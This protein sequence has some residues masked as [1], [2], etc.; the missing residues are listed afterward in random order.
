MRHFRV[1]KICL[2]FCTN[3]QILRG[4]IVYNIRVILNWRCNVNANS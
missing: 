2:Y 3:G 4:D 1:F